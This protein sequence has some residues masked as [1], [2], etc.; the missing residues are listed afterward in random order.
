MNHLIS[1]V[2]I[3][4]SLGLFFGYVDPQYMEI[5]TLKAERESYDEAL[6]NSKSLQEERDRLIAKLDGMPDADLQAL[7]KLLPND[8]DNVRL[9]IDIDEMAKAY[10]MRIRNFKT[11]VA[12]KK[13][14]IGRDNSTYG[15]LTLNFST[16][17]SYTTFLA[18]MRDLERSLRIIDVSSISFAAVE[19]NPLYDYNVTIKTYWLK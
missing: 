9:I 4:A 5:K 12:E 8:I 17:A 15:T 19:T 11:D 18:F 3:V 10:N 2:V 16:S 7:T 14:T 13:D 6:N 1:V